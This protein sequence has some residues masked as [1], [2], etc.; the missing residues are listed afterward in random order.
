[1]VQRIFIVEC[2]AKHNSS[3]T[4]AELFAE[5]YMTGNVLAIPPAKFAMQNL[6]AKWRKTGSV[7]NQNR[8]YPKRIRTPKNIAK[9]KQSLEQS[10]TKSQRHLSMQVGIKMSS[11]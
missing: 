1:M 7:L 2:Y 5:E 9:L 11:C 10:P 6:V 8:N 4:C 3:K